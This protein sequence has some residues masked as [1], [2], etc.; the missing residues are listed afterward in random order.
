VQGLPAGSTEA[1]S[2][3]AASN[4]SCGPSGASAI[5]CTVPGELT[6]TG[7]SLS[8][9]VTFKTP[10]AGTGMALTGTSVMIETHLDNGATFF[11][12]TAAATSTTALTEPDPNAVSTFVPTSTTTAATLFTGVNTAAGVSGAIPIVKLSAIPPINDPFTTTVIVPP[13]SAATT[14]NVVESEAAGSCGTNPRCFQSQLTVPGSFAFLT[15]ILRRDVTTLLS[16]SRRDH[17]DD[18]R[19]SG[20]SAI[21]SSIVYYT[22]DGSTALNPVPNCSTDATLP[23]SHEPC[24]FSRKAY[25]KRSTA[26]NPVPAGLEGDW[27]YVIHALDNGRYTN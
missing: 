2:F 18:D 11:E 14:A 5:E 7:Q 25:P 17:D 24:V 12:T 23:R 1:A 26:R 19:H 10:G 3:L 15:I 4:A 21:D 27:E 16:S 13:N 8:F 20:Q 6:A 9:T 22:P